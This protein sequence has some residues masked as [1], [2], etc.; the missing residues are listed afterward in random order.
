MKQ[1]IDAIM[2]REVSRKEFLGMSGLAVASI[3]GL[4]SILKLANGQGLF[5]NKA[6]RGYGS[7]PYGK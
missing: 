2:Q 1:Q 7:T 5:A 6:S 3:F 4:G